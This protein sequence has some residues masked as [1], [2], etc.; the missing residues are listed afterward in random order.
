MDALALRDEQ[1]SRR[2]AKSCGPDIPTLISSERQCLRIAAYDGGNKARLT[3]EIT[4]ETVKTIARGMPGETG[5][6]VVDLL[7]VLF[8]FR[9]RGCGRF[10]RP[11][12]PAPLSMRELDLQNSGANGVARTRKLAEGIKATRERLCRIPLTHRSCGVNAKALPGSRPS[13]MTGANP[14]VRPIV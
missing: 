10:G 2:T 4:K 13:Q 9:T 8:I 6:T 11:A 7:G 5:V 12:F 3:E 1:R 14:A